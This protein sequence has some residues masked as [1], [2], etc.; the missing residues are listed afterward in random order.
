MIQSEQFGRHFWISPDGDFCSCP[1]F[2]DGNPD[3]SNIDYLEEWQGDD[4]TILEFNEI[5]KIYQRLLAR[6]EALIDLYDFIKL[7]DCEIITAPLL[8]VINI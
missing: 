6:K 4:L 3:T 5:I 7:K 1:T 8:K 2:V